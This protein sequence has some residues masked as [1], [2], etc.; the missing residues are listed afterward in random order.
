MTI[1]SCLPNID[2]TIDCSQQECNNFVINGSIA[3]YL[4]VNC[5]DYFYTRCTGSIFI[6]PNGGCEIICVGDNS[7]KSSTILYNGDISDNG[8]ITI[9]CTD[10]YPCQYMQI[11][12]EYINQLNIKCNGRPEGWYGYG[13][14]I[15]MIINASH[16]KQI[17][18][19]TQD[20]AAMFR[21]ILNFQHAYSIH[22]VGFAGFAYTDCILHA[23]Y[24]TYLQITCS[25]SSVNGF[26]ACYSTDNIYYIPH[27]TTFN[28][29]GLGC[30]NLGNLFLPSGNTSALKINYHSCLECDTL[31]D[32]SRDFNLYCYDINDILIGGNCD[33]KTN[34]INDN[35]G[36]LN[37]WN[38]SLQTFDDITSECYTPPTPAPTK[39]NRKSNI[40]CLSK[41]ESKCDVDCIGSKVCANQ[42]IDASKSSY[43]TLICNGQQA[44]QY[45]V[46]ICP[47]GG[48]S[49][50]C[51][52]NWA[53]S[54]MDIIYNGIIEDKA[55]ISID[56]DGAI[57]CMEMIINANYINK[58]E[59]KCKEKES[60]SGYTTC[61]KLILNGQY[62]NQVNIDLI[63]QSMNEAIINVNNAK[64]V[65][66]TSKGEYGFSGGMLNARYADY[67]VIKCI[68]SKDDISACYN[69]EW[70]IPGNTDI[71][72][73]G[74]GCNKMGNINVSAVAS[75]MN[76]NIYGC[77]E[78]NI[79]INE[80]ITEFNVVC[81]R[82]Y[83]NRDGLGWGIYQKG[84]L[85]S[86]CTSDCECKDM[87]DNIK[88]NDDSSNNECPNPQNN[89]Q[90]I[91]IIVAIIG[92]LITV[93]IIIIVIYLMKCRKPAVYTPSIVNNNNV[94]LATV[95]NNN[96]NQEGTTSVA[97]PV[98]VATPV[99]VQ[100]QAHVSGQNTNECI[101]QAYVGV[102][103]GEGGVQTQGNIQYQ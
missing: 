96:I 31:Y 64:S 21:S 42:L 49:I 61:H 81:G 44:C 23:Q 35:C 10:E 72:C 71:N 39:W 29:Y 1:N 73:Y 41:T 43:L 36:C 24:A 6:C 25:G 89:M 34:I 50:K 95:S 40:S 9:T 22:I 65:H 45:S 101:S 80:C 58:I 3:S 88:F 32:C 69:N 27:N 18:I 5:Y 20:R 7:C 99:M 91:I 26:G 75:D 12:A 52:Y 97:M 98:V 11:S 63:E 19:I 16:A 62:A 82:G 14:C 79:D 53:C 92:G 78:C 55:T 54:Y 59:L 17:S 93:C 83:D 2:C 8:M 56:C 15:D 100:M 48:C 66:L 46:V 60:S 13:A 33:E 68:A 77:G 70:Y 47:V 57:V 85:K 86:S 30:D 84:N 37:I 90:W 38:N 28:C 67:V 103:E 94:E 76:V 87:I 74:F 51:S 102:N 4:T